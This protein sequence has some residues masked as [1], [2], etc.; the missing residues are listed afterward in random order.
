MAHHPVQ[1]DVMDIPV[2][3]KCPEVAQLLDAKDNR[4]TAKFLAVDLLERLAASATV[5]VRR[6]RSQAVVPQVLL[7]ARDSRGSAISAAE[8]RRV[9]LG[10]LVQDHHSAAKSELETTLDSPLLLQR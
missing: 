2:T 6:P 3:A 1:L 5:M 4:V 7:D 8:V 10:A 9:R